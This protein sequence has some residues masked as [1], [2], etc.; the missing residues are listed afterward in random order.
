[1]YLKVLALV[2]VLVGVLVWFTWSRLLAVL[3]SMV[4][5]RQGLRLK[6]ES[7][8]IKSATQ[9]FVTCLKGPVGEAQFRRIQLGWMPSGGGEEEEEDEGQ[10][11]MQKFLSLL[12]SFRLYVRFV[13]VR[14][15]LREDVRMEEHEKEAL[16]H[17][18]VGHG[19]SS[20][21]NF[22]IK[23]ILPLMSIDMNDIE[24][25]TA[26]NATVLK[27]Q[28]IGLDAK[29]PGEV[30]VFENMVVFP[31]RKS[32]VDEQIQNEWGLFEVDRMCFQCAEPLYL[33]LKMSRKSRGKKLSVSVESIRMN[34]EN[35]YL[36]DLQKLLHSFKR[37]KKSI[38]HSDEAPRGSK[39]VFERVLGKSL[40]ALSI[41]VDIRSMMMK[42]PIA[43]CSN[44]ME[45]KRILFGCHTTP[46]RGDDRGRI[47]ATLVW[48]NILLRTAAKA[49]TPVLECQSS[50]SDCSCLVL[51]TQHSNHDDCESTIESNI[52]L[53]L[54]ALHTKFNH[55]Q[56][57]Q[58]VSC[59][60]HSSSQEKRYDMPKSTNILKIVTLS[61]GNGSSL[62]FFDGSSC[63]L[64]QSIDSA[65]CVAEHRKEGDLAITYSVAG[66]AM[67]DSEGSNKNDLNQVLST[68]VF[69][70]SVLREDKGLSITVSVAS[71]AGVLSEKLMQNLCKVKRSVSSSVKSFR[72]KSKKSTMSDKRLFLGLSVD[73]TSINVAIVSRYEV[74]KKF[75]SVRRDTSVDSAIALR[76]ESF[77]LSKTIGGSYQGNG[78]A[79]NLIHYE[80]AG[81]E[82][83]SLDFDLMT[84]S[85]RSTL[86]A[87]DAF[88]IL[89]SDD[90][91]RR[92]VRLG[93]LKFYGDAEALISMVHFS[94]S[95]KSLSM[96][97]RAD[98]AWIPKGNSEKKRRKTM[99]LAKTA[100]FCLPLTSDREISFVLG[101]CELE[102]S[103]TDLGKHQVSLALMDAAVSLKGSL[104]IFHTIHSC[105]IMRLYHCILQ[106]SIRLF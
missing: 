5:T 41:D 32:I 57:E 48:D 31:G 69:R 19:G 90:C 24:V 64:H 91:S 94:K 79:L 89:D 13:G 29:R 106:E 18:S 33:F 66:I 85:I 17:D 105:L 27:A 101:G 35:R 44:E 23:N 86:L 82:N 104:N 88:E 40:P 36:D 21:A 51:V 56:L 68:Q 54:Q 75:S 47:E 103:V 70:G 38:R 9:V 37:T 50:R 28:R 34:S 77:V 4:A 96:S 63:I 67:A 61:L 43:G 22:F 95:V 73:F 62:Q 53:D 74:P 92:T 71:L 39:N 12:G 25:L 10:N 8:T 46:W 26:S 87:L 80:G 83:F 2:V 55:C 98:K 52:R 14:I 6:V 16:N 81:V 93:Q 102:S 3:V 11:T 84:G 60:Q 49:A 100:R 97:D 76:A 72:L 20:N 99:I 65:S 42:S 59:V 15:R 45:V 1:M 58:W 78:N 30:L 7:L